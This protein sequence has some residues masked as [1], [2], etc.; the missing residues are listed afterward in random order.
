[1]ETK[2]KEEIQKVVTDIWQQALPVERVGADDDFFSLGGHSLVLVRTF[3]DIGEATGIT[4]HLPSFDGKTT[5][6]QVAETFWEIGR[7]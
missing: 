6:A 4:P 7:S 3:L 5:A 2:T 1:M